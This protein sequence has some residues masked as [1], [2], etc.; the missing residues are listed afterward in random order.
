MNEGGRLHKKGTQACLFSFKGRPLFEFYF[1]INCISTSQADTHEHIRT[2]TSIV[3]GRF[4]QH[5][6]HIKTS[7]QSKVSVLAQLIGTNVHLYTSKQDLVKYYRFC[8]LGYIT[9]LQNLGHNPFSP[10][11]RLCLLSIFNIWETKYSF[12]IPSMCIA[13]WRL[14]CTVNIKSLAS[15]S[16]WLKHVVKDNNYRARARASD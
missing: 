2:Q 5:R 1:D 9:Y 6:I 10:F 8:F 12:R 14:A 11:S 13:C 15:Q 16:Y 3:P 7:A 4:H